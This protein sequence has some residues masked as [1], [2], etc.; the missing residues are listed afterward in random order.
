VSQGL[1]KD[2]RYEFLQKVDPCGERLNEGLPELAIN[3]KRY[4]TIPTE[5]TYR[6]VAHGDKYSTAGSEISRRWTVAPHFHFMSA[7]AKQA[8]TK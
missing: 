1:I 7:S 8:M 2:E 4:Y 5:A 3:F 6:R